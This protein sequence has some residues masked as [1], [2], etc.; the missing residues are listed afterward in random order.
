M[1]SGSTSRTYIHSTFQLNARQEDG[2]NGIAE[3][4]STTLYGGVEES[5]NGVVAELT[6]C[7]DVIVVGAELIPCKEVVVAFAGVALSV[8]SAAIRTL[9]FGEAIGMLAQEILKVC[10]AMKSNDRV[11]ATVGERI[12]ALQ[13]IVT[14]IEEAKCNKSA[15]FQELVDILI[16]LKEVS[17]QSDCSVCLCHRMIDFICAAV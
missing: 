4:K 7:I 12:K 1:L 15:P 17:T 10:D 3:T 11:V 14:G 5:T 6:P 13:Q 2:A 16:K 8:G 9:P